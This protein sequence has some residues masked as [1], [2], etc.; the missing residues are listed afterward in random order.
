V[1]PVFGT[2]LPQPAKGDFKML[3][4]VLMVWKECTPQ[5]T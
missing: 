3:S 1:Y 2:L 5:K 4:Q